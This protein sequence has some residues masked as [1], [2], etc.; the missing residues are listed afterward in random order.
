MSGATQDPV[1]RLELPRSFV[2]YA[3][4]CAAERPYKESA[5]F[6]AEVTK[7]A[8]EQPVEPG[9]DEEGNTTP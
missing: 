1:V 7:Q 4:Q 8:S 9:R 2:N 6:I 5:L 3:L